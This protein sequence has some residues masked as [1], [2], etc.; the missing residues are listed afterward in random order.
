[1]KLRNLNFTALAALATLALSTVASQAAISYSSGDVFLGFRQSTNSSSDFVVDIGP[2]SA[3]RNGTVSS[4]TLNNLNSTLSGLFGSGWATDSTVTFGLI[5]T[6]QNVA[7][8]G[9]P[10]RVLY[11]SEPIGNPAPIQSSNQSTQA[12]NIIGF[13]NYYQSLPE[14]A[15][16]NATVGNPGNSQSFTTFV[17]TGFASNNLIP[18]E[19]NVGGGLELYRVPQTA[20]GPV[21]DLG[22]LTYA[23]GDS[24][25]FTS[26]TAVP[27]PSTAGLGGLLVLGL[28]F[29]RHRKSVLA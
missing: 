21:T 7:N 16:S 29:C 19:G 26:M 17:G 24:F 12:A 8:A 1:M 28:A 9:D 11:V 5:G 18:I 6:T 15:V 23:G 20:S 27:E 2:G 14:S 3:F 25:T 10:T 4:F 13:K 22:Q